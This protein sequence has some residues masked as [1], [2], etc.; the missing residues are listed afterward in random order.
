MFARVSWV[1]SLRRTLT[2]NCVGQRTL[3]T[4][5]TLDTLANKNEPAGCKGHYRK[6]V[7]VRI[8]NLE[9]NIKFNFEF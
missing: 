9:K 7:W 5:E 6:G 1:Y 4:L 3:E 8:R 2:L